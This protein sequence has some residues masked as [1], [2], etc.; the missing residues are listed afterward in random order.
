MTERDVRVSVIVTVD[1][2]TEEDA[3]EARNEAADDAAWEQMQEWT[4]AEDPMSIH[5]GVQTMF[6]DEPPY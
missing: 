2:E 6:G 3:L 5:Y 4:I 1:G